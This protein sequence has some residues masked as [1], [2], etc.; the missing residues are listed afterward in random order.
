MKRAA[1]I[2]PLLAPGCAG[3]QSAN[4]RDAVQGALIGRLFDVFLGVAVVVYAL[5][6]V[7]LALALLR[8]RRHRRRESGLQGEPAPSLERP[9]RIG[10]ILFASA[11]ALI[12]FGLAIATW[13]TD[14]ALAKA[15]AEA[16]L[17]VE[18]IGNQ[19][20]WEVRYQDP[21]ASRIVRTANELHLP[22][23]QTTRLTLKSNDVIH[24]MWIPNLSGK[25]D[26][27]PGRESDLALHPTRT[28]TFRAQCAEF[29][30]MQHANMALDV[31]VESPADFRR[32]YEAQLVPQPAPGGAA[33]AGYAIFQN[34][35]CASCHAVGGTPAS[36][37]V[38]PDLTHVASRNTIAA[39]ALPMSRENLARWVSDP[40]AVKP[41]N[42]MP[43]VPLS[44]SELGA[45]V[46]Y[47]ETLK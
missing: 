35:Q 42:N 30:G 11:T 19:W 13:L 34:R 17:E 4:G 21:V 18:V 23:G 36:G 31:T 39:G 5:V 47:L 6:I 27:I 45:L 22:V 40:Q 43:K 33:A 32:W 26:M 7:Y 25:Q 41:G 8:G 16:P 3:I 10:L 46:A 38:A 44:Q 9:W 1:L 37:Q 20:W 12:L 2:L 24:S 14:R 28:G 15:G 29:C